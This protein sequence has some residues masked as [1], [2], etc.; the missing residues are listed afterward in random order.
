[1]KTILAIFA[2]PDDEAFGPAGTLALLSK[3]YNIELVCVTDG[4]N[5]EKALYSQ[6]ITDIRKHE[7][8]RSA[9]ILGIT[10]IHYL[11][12]IDGSLNNLVYSEMIEEIS[13]LIIQKEPEI[14]LTFEPQG[15]TG[16]LDHIAV[17]SVIS[18]IFYTTNIIP[19]LYMYCLHEEQRLQIQSYFVYFPP[20]YKQKQIQVSIDISSVHE[21]KLNAVHAHMSQKKDQAFWLPIIQKFK[22][23]HF[24][25]L[26]K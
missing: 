17:T 8:E 11:D 10:K 4:Q 16:H 24:L 13:K 9:A 22:K 23:E 21:N 18:Q 14:V 26:K 12:F 1:M 20:G 6:N 15:F 7:L 5:G 2:H 19:N 3:K 25:V